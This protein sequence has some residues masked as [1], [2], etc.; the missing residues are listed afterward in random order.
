M[1]LNDVETWEAKILLVSG[2]LDRSV[3]V[4]NVFTPS[5]K[6][7]VQGNYYFLFHDDDA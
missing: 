1:F 5:T 3:G 7:R 4:G 2:T 6:G